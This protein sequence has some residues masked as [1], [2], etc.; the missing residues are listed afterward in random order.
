ML[1]LVVPPESF[2]GSVGCVLSETEQRQCTYRITSVTYAVQHAT[3][4]LTV[5]SDILRQSNVHRSI[6]RPSAD[7]YPWLLDACALLRDVQKKVAGS[8]GS[9]LPS[10]LRISLQLCQAPAADTDIDSTIHRKAGCS[11]VLSCAEVVERLE[12]ITTVEGGPPIHELLCSAFLRIAEMCTT[13]Q[14][15]LRLTTSHLVPIL[16]KLSLAGDAMLMGTDLWVGRT[17]FPHEGWELEAD[18]SQS[19]MPRTPTTRHKRPKNAQNNRDQ[20]G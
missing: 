5:M 17:S 6:S 16:E 20:L 8:A 3:S 10:L 7:Q 13:D 9:C 11:L 2:F 1:P 18:T 14:A 19:G 15:V 12:S 4:L